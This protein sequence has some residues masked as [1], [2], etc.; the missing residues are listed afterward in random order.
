MTRRKLHIAIDGPR[1]AACGHRLL[2]RG[3]GDCPVTGKPEQRLLHCPD[4]GR[5]ASDAVHATYCVGD[6]ATGPLQ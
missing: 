1:N 3:S 6:A 5:T 2:A 4:C